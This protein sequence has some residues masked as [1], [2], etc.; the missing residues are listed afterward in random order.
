[1]KKYNKL[2]RDKIPDVIEQDGHKA[3]FKTLSEKSF[4][5]A[6]DKKLMEEVKDI[7]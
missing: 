5:T 4:F 1:L 7:K 3:K 6:L 2:V